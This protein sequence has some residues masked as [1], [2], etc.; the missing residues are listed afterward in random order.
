[1]PYPSALPPSRPSTFRVEL[2]VGSMVV[3]RILRSTPSEQIS[4]AHG[5][6]IR[7]GKHVPEFQDTEYSSTCSLATD[8]EVESG[9]TKQQDVCVCLFV[10]FPSSIRE[11]RLCVGIAL[12]YDKSEFWF[13]LVR[14]WHA[15]CP[16]GHS[17]VTLSS[18]QITCFVLVVRLGWDSVTA[19]LMTR[20]ALVDN[21]AQFH[22][23]R[24]QVCLST[25]RIHLLMCCFSIGLL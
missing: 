24:Q 16:R 23:L 3:F 22:I 8:L 11:V 21:R 19:I 9:K 15:H 25:T 5:P 13:R 18:V 17:H 2:H 12:S 20:R 6:V 14:H 10:C 4:I 7:H 1:M